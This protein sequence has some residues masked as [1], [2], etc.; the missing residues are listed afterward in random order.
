MVSILIQIIKILVI[1]KSPLSSSG[2]QSL[3]S[4]PLRRTEK[5][6]HWDKLREMGWSLSLN[7]TQRE[8]E[9]TDGA[10]KLIIIFLIWSSW[11]QRLHLE[12]HQRVCVCACERGRERVFWTL[13]RTIWHTHSHSF[14]L[15][16][17]WSGQKSSFL[18]EKMKQDFENI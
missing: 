15:A 13:L 10:A 5:M 2:F 11:R 8:D 3:Q 4:R 18:C 6:Q 12:A 1:L 14:C 17:T 16:H 9:E 7:E